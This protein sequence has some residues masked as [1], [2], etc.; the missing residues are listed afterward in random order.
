M[1]ECTSGIKFIDYINYRALI[2]YSIFR[3]NFFNSID[4]LYNDKNNSKMLYDILANGNSINKKWL[5]KA[6]FEKACIDEEDF[7]KFIKNR[8]KFYDFDKQNKELTRLFL[9]KCIE[10]NADGAKKLFRRIKKLIRIPKKKNK[11][12]VTS[13]ES[14]GK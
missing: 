3:S 2:I 13:N 5:A 12:L 14:A 6:I 7:Y 11:K 10:G 9:E 1:R 8:N 4:F